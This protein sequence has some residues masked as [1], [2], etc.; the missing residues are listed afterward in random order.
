MGGEVLETSPP[1]FHCAINATQIKSRS[2]KVKTAC[3]LS[4]S[5]VV[6]VVQ[7]AMHCVSGDVEVSRVLPESAVITPLSNTVSELPNQATTGLKQ[8]HGI[9]QQMLMQCLLPTPYSKL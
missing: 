3:M 7:A 1:T 4:V 8:S 6:S 9:S 5:G 2:L